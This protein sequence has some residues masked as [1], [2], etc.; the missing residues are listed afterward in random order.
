MSYKAFWKI[1]S[2]LCSMKVPW[3]KVLLEIKNF[4]VAYNGSVHIGRNIYV[5]KTNVNFRENN[6]LSQIK[7][8]RAREMHQMIKLRRNQSNRNQ[9]TTLVLQVCCILGAGSFFLIYTWKSNQCGAFSL[10]RSTIPL[11]WY[12][13]AHFLTSALFVCV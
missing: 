12:Y 1:R 7:Q 10:S 11:F 2:F 6:I 4:V 8:E 9:K 3:K 13:L 5:W